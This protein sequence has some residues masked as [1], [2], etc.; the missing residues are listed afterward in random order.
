VK[1]ILS[2]QKADEERK[3][4]RHEIWCRKRA[5][6]VDLRFR[7]VRNHVHICYLQDIA[8]GAAAEDQRIF[9]RHIEGLG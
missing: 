3:E 7:R 8:L 9:P 1:K 4:V 2:A 5:E 6:G